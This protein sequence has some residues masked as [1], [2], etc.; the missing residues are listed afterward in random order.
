MKRA[1]LAAVLAL[2]ACG[3]GEARPASPAV[4]PAAPSAI[5]L[6]AH[7]PTQAEEIVFGDH[8]PGTLVKPGQPGK[9][10]AIVL[11]QGSGP[12]DRDWNSPLITT[13]N[14]S[15]KL[16]AEALASHGAVVVRF[17]KA[18]VGAN[19]TKP[20]GQTIDVYV[21]EA[22][23]AL[24]YV[25]SRPEVDATRVYIAGHSE[26]G[27]HAIRTADV[28]GSALAGVLLLSTT[29]RTLR[30]ILLAQITTQIERAAP[31]K[32]EA[33]VGPFRTAMD[34]FIAGKTIDPKT[35]TPIPGLQQL[36][37]S[38]TAPASATLARG[39][40]V[41]DPLG[42]IA[43]IGV[44]IFIYNGEKDVQVDPKIDPPLLANAAKANKDVTVFLAPEADHVLKHETKTVDELRADM[45][46][47]EAAYNSPDRGLDEATVAA[48]VGWLAKH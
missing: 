21:A 44:P 1:A 26:G 13:K 2:G 46:A 47:L 11:F 3:G 5:D 15:G 23:A 30:D 24:A 42:G 32:A 22:R 7:L 18:G 9:F 36:L 10:P 6:A 35:A 8:V 40:L 29:G 17:D 37:G 39:L 27:L 20:L 28:E 45:A 12:T 31:G 48:I 38:L 25:R 41:A 33:L 34:E 14:G 16:L 43:K 19:T 4:T